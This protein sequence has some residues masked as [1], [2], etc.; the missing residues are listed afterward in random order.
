VDT[1]TSGTAS[2]VPGKWIH[3]SP[4]SRGSL[5]RRARHAEQTDAVVG[6][7]SLMLVSRRSGLGRGLRARRGIQFGGSARQGN[8]AAAALIFMAEQRA[9]L[10][11]APMDDNP[12]LRP[13]N[14]TTDARRR[15][16]PARYA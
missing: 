9:L 10:R 11:F 1:R 5:P 14:R 8:G 16:T 13:S 12:G 7:S 3:W 2:T 4:A 6:V 15:D